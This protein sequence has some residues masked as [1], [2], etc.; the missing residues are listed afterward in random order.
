[1]RAM[2]TLA[3]SGSLWA[4]FL[5]VRPLMVTI[6]Q[7]KSPLVGFQ[8]GMQMD[9]VK[10]PTDRSAASE[11]HPSAMRLTASGLLLNRSKHAQTSLL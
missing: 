4:S 1:M 10:R 8:Q 6:C 7:A 11:Q 9:D 2:A 3:R 5:M